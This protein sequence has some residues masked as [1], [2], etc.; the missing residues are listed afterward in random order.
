MTESLDLWWRVA[1]REPG[2]RSVEVDAPS[3]WTLRDW[4]AYADR[5]HGPG[6]IV[7]PIAGMP[8]PTGTGQHR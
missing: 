3:G 1:L 2:G 5:Y 7:T 8:K 4:Q 6:C